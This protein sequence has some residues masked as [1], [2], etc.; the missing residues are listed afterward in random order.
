MYLIFG[1]EVAIKLVSFFAVKTVSAL[2]LIAGIYLHS[3]K[4]FL[5]TS[6]LC[7]SDV[8]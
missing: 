3:A 2:F 8:P 1:S 6:A 7:L 4:F 5:Q